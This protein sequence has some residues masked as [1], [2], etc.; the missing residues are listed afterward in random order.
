[1]RWNP[2]VAGTL[3]TLVLI[4]LLVGRD[5]QAE[6]RPPHLV[7]QTGIYAALGSPASCGPSLA[8]DVLP[9]SVFERWGLRAEYRGY[10]GLAE[11]SI[12]AGA[13]FEAGAS[14]SQLAL[15]LLTFGGMTDAAAPII[16]AGVD[17]SFWL[18]GPIGISTVADVQI[19]ID[20]SSTRPALSAV[21][22]LH[23]GK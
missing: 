8:L 4:S 13:I 23:L 14:R 20:G 10:K 21:L 22:S 1:M 18:L 5:A 12:L 7:L 6:D 16:G 19:I 2:L 11:G 9:G 17:W 15:K 3:G